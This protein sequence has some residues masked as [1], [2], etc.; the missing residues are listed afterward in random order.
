LYS[1]SEA[2]QFVREPAIVKYDGVKSN[3]G[4]LR[5]HTQ[6]SCDMHFG[7]SP[8]AALTYMADGN[9]AIFHTLPR[10]EPTPQ[11]V[12]LLL[13]II[14]HYAVHLINLMMEHEQR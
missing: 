2:A 9:A 3:F 14:Q 6:Q 11:F 1:H 12:R 13:R 10:T 8:G 4:A 5:E 7:T